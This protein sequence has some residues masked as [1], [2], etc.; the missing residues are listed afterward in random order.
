[1]PFAGAS[2]AT[3]PSYQITVVREL[4]CKRR[5]PLADFSS[6]WWTRVHTL[7]QNTHRHRARKNGPLQLQQLYRDLRRLADTPPSAAASIVTPKDDRTWEQWI[8]FLQQIELADDG[9]IVAHATRANRL[10]KRA[11]QRAI[12]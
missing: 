2:R 10:A 9:H 12:R 11:Q 3:G 1:M 4:Q 7:L 8:L 6:N 5:A